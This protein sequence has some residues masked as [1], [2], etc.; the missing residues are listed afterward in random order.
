MILRSWLFVPG[1]S[2][3]KLAKVEE[4]PADLLIID[5]EDSVAD[6]RTAIARVG[7]SLATWLELRLI[8]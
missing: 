3:R 7:T 4:T 5:L 8:F 1:D 6:D 2:E